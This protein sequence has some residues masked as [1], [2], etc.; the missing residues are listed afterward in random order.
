MTY[1]VSKSRYCSATANSNVSPRA[2]ARPLPWFSWLLSLG[3]VLLISPFLWRATSASGSSGAYSGAPCWQDCELRNRCYVHTCDT[4]LGRVSLGVAPNQARRTATMSLLLPAV[5]RKLLR[6]RMESSRIHSITRILAF[7]YKR[8][9]QPGYLSAQVISKQRRISKLRAI[10]FV[11]NT[12]ETS[13]S[14]ELRVD[15]F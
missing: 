3:T 13:S 6:S 15:T 5:E 4:P 2:Y 7:V 9:I 11:N 12:G 14:N 8:K 10:R 1:A